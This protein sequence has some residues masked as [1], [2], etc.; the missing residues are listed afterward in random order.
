MHQIISIWCLKFIDSFICSEGAPNDDCKSFLNISFLDWMIFNVPP[1][2]VNTALCWVYLQ[3]HFLGLPQRLR[4][5]FGRLSD[6]NENVLDSVRADREYFEKKME[7]A[8]RRKY[9]Q[10]GPMNFQQ[11]ATLVLFLVLV[12]LWI[13]KDPQFMP[14]WDVWFQKSAKGRSYISEATPTLGIVMIL[15]MLP[16][17]WDYYQKAMKGSKSFFWKFLRFSQLS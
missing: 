1:M 9:N 4:K 16:S 17:K 6:S 15:F 12:V 5:M 8:I 11:I 10:L 3:L 13:F 2:V 14:G 7:V